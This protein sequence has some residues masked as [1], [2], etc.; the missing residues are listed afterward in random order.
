MNKIRQT[1]DEARELLL[2]HADEH[3]NKV[4]IKLIKLTGKL[5]EIREENDFNEIDL[6]ELKQ[7]LK[8]LEEELSKQSNISIQ[9]DSSSFIKKISVINFS[10]KYF[11]YI[12][13]KIDL[14]KRR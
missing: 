2:K 12:N 13:K 6:N 8:E 4:E 10:R 11:I 9:Q 7:K 14:S 5:K 1:A 3:I